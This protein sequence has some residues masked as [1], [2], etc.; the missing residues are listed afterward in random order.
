MKF[1]SILIL[2]FHIICT[3]ALI[4]PCKTY[5]VS[6]NDPVSFH[7]TLYKDCSSY[8]KTNDVYFH[9]NTNEYAK[10]PDDT[11]IFCCRTRPIKNAFFLEIKNRKNKE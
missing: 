4:N 7:Q 6:K 5:K 10:S 9:T 8:L 2:I 3:S 11:N 1:L